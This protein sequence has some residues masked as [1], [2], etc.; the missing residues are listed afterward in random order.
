MVGLMEIL[1]MALIVFSCTS[2]IVQVGFLI[3]LFKGNK[4]KTE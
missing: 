2:A 4:D 3:Y 1:T